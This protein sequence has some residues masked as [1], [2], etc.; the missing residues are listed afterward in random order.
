M[1]VLGFVNTVR[2]L[3]GRPARR[4]LPLTG[5]ERDRDDRC[6]VSMALGLEVG[7]SAHPPW[8]A[9]GRWV[10]RLSDAATARRVGARTGQA[11]RA[12]PPEVRLPEALVD[13][14]VSHHLG[15]VVPDDDGRVRG[16][17]LP[18]ADG[19]PAFRTPEAPVARR[20][21]GHGTTRTVR[22]R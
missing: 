12:H 5:C 8:A 3:C 18:G 10:M 21:A 11:W 15:L 4:A 20:N 16:W 22:A 9:D 7:D 14:A 17:W 6:V 19:F 13:L 1:A 2:A